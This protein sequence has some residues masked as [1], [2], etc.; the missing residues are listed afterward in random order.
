MQEGL[1]MDTGWINNT[2]GNR[3][4]IYFLI[5]GWSLSMCKPLNQIKESEMKEQTINKEDEK[6]MIE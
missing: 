1:Q 3:K 5:W 4:N 2:L 6:M